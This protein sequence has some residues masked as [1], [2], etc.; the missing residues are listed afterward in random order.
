MRQGAKGRGSVLD[1][2]LIL[3]FSF[4]LVGAVLR[5]RDL[6]RGEGED[7]RAPYLITAVVREIPTETAACIEAGEELYTVEGELYG[8]VRSVSSAPTRWHLVS[9]GAYYEGVWP[10]EWVCDL[11][12]TVA[13]P[14]SESGG[15]LLREGRWPLLTGQRT[16][17]YSNRG[18]WTAEI[19]LFR[20]AGEEDK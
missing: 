15:V 10:E 14:G 7:S 13:V 4:C 16:V 8:V 19:R 2:F 17:L 9:N 11:T 5:Y 1:L 3:L 6:R 12:L 18:Q 20:P